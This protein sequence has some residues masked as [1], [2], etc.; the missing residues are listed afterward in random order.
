MSD[1]WAVK[2]QGDDAALARNVSFAYAGVATVAWVA[3]GDPDG[4]ALAAH[5]GTVALLV[6]TGL[7]FWARAS[8]HRANAREWLE[9]IYSN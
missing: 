1:P 4:F 5:A 8:R 7:A 3:V 6:G 9:L 2:R